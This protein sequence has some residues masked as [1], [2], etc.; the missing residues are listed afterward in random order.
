MLFSLKKIFKFVTLN[1]YDSNIM[2]FRTGIS[3]A[4]EEF[5]YSST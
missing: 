4:K 5:G 2:M 3:S 1:C